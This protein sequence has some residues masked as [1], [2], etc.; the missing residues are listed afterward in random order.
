L[1]QHPSEISKFDFELIKILEKDIKILCTFHSPINPTYKSL[2][3]SS[4][5][6]K[7]KIFV[8]YFY[9]KL[10]APPSPGILSLFP[11]L[12]H[13]LCPPP[14]TDQLPPTKAIGPAPWLFLSL[15]LSSSFTSSLAKLVFN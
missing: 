1:S 12:S 5:T 14:I 7:S 15:L 11:C 4:L 10:A 2:S 3:I 8:L 9:V 6:T 13:S